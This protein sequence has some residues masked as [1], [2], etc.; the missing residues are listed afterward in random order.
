MNL[1]CYA[2]YAP[3]VTEVG[4]Q[5]V[6]EHPRRI[7]SLPALDA[8]TI[9]PLIGVTMLAA[10]YGGWAVR[11]EAASSSRGKPIALH[12]NWSVEHAPK[13][14]TSTKNIEKR[15]LV[16]DAV[17]P[18]GANLK[19][20]FPSKTGAHEFELLCTPKIL[21]PPLLVT[22]D[23]KKVAGRFWIGCVF[24]RRDGVPLSSH[25]QMA[26][27]D[28]QE[29]GVEVR[30]NDGAGGKLLYRVM[31]NPSTTQARIEQARAAQK[32]KNAP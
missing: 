8:M 17:V 18:S 12:V 3:P 25:P 15:S 22:P 14:S 13:G 9:T 26:T 32:V 10:A 19:L 6:N 28:N 1:L 7:D 20:F 31:I 11:A 5:S 27:W 4:L 24:K 23:G 30:D 29:I 2:L 16:T 21:E